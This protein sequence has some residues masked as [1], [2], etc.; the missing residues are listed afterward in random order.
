[1]CWRAPSRHT[2]LAIEVWL[3]SGTHQAYLNAAGLG[4][5][6]GDGQFPHPGPE[7]ILE[8]YYSLPVGSRKGNSGLSVHRQSGLQPRPRFG[9]DSFP[10]I[11][12][13]VLKNPR[14]GKSSLSVRN[15][16]GDARL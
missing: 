7:Q 14:N 6:V 3:R 9:L 4:F 15:A 13:A 12:H 11:A 2:G 5:L 1:V 8:T 10:S 16:Y